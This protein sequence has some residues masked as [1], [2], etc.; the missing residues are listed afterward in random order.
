MWINFHHT[1][2][3]WIDIFPWKYNLIIPANLSDFIK[4]IFST[5]TS[6]LAEIDPAQLSLF[7][8]SF[9][10][11][12][13]FDNS[14]PFFQTW[15]PTN[16]PTNRLTREDLEAQRPKLKKCFKRQKRNFLSICCIILGVLIDS[17]FYLELEI[18]KIVALATE[19]YRYVWLRNH[20]LICYFFHRQTNKRTNTRPENIYLVYS[21]RVHT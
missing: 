10:L 11:S 14:W 7:S 13:F 18:L 6:I 17:N 12:F 19:I 16:Q 1:N 5:L 3:F 21:R 4:L 8:S 15:R 9:F 2:K 20:S